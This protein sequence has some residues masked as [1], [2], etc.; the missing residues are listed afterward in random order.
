[1]SLYLV[2]AQAAQAAPPDDSG[3]PWLN[4]LI[5]GG[6]LLLFIGAV[7]SQGA[8]G[9]A[10]PGFPPSVPPTFGGGGGSS[11]RIRINADDVSVRITP[12]SQNR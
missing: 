6:L 7:A 3:F 5:F 1:M 11:P 10:P 4:I 9:Q 8:G 2:L 12:D